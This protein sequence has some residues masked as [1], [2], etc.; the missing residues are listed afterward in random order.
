MF[1]FPPWLLKSCNGTCTLGCPYLFWNLGEF[2]TARAVCLRKTCDAKNLQSAS[3]PTVKGHCHA[4]RLHV[5]FY[6]FSLFL[7]SQVCFSLTSNFI[8]AVNIKG[9]FNTA[10][11]TK[12]EKD[13]PEGISVD[14]NFYKTF[15]SLQEYFC[16]P[17]SLTLA[18]VKWQKFTSSLTIVLDTCE[19][20]PL[21]DEDGDANILEEEAVTFNI[22]YLTSSN[23]MDLELKDP[24]F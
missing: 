4:D 20:Q 17:A 5:D 1:L 9:V 3:S 14:F 16:N 22:K 18:P 15:W 24:S 2:L 8:A 10:N 19:A 21:S 12:Y 11:E 7:C 23:L 6:G 13:P